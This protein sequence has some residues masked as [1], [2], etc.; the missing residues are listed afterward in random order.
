M[1]SIG[2]GLALGEGT[3]WRGLDYFGRGLDLPSAIREYRRELADTKTVSGMVTFPAT[4][5]IWHNLARLP[6]DVEAP[7]GAGFPTDYATRLSNMG[8]MPTVYFHTVDW[9][10][11]DYSN[12]SYADGKHDAELYE[13]GRQAGVAGVKFLLRINQE[14]N[15]SW[16]PWSPPHDPG[17]NLDFIGMWRRCVKQIRAGMASVGAD[18][19]NAGI[20][21]T[22]SARGYKD[23]EE[24]WDWYPGDSYVDVL[25][26]DSYISA[27]MKTRNLA[28]SYLPTYT[29]LTEKVAGKP[30]M[31]G[32]TGIS[33]ANISDADRALIWREGLQTFTRERFWRR[34]KA[35]LYFNLDMRGSEPNDWRITGEMQ[36]VFANQFTRER[37][38]REITW[39]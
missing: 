16:A 33:R 11:P 38:R 18:P 37:Y 22:P 13:W 24:I 27:N 8:I 9:A 35:I 36:E 25:G 26:F 10:S 29:E 28:R 2:L 3:R 17:N 4:V 12:Q 7:Q 19:A 34:L 21:W 31:V 5:A 32:E 15:G 6:L 23:V 30:V 20:W 1:R 39:P 14:M